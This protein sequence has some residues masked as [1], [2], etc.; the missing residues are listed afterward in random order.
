MVDCVLLVLRVCSVVVVSSVCVFCL[1]KKCVL[2]FYQLL[3]TAGWD[4][5]IRIWDTTTALCLHVCAHHN[6]DVYSIVSHPERPFTYVSCSR[7]T[8]IRVWEVGDVV[9]LIRLT[10]VW[11]G[12]IGASAGGGVGGGSLERFVNADETQGSVLHLLGYGNTNED[13]PAPMDGNGECMYVPCV[14]T[15]IFLLCL[16]SFCFFAH[17]TLN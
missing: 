4:A 12:G 2:F 1:L 9:S 8:T 11:D 15:F 5:T 16:L 6:A 14:R 7:D 13:Q 3:L 17:G 10:C